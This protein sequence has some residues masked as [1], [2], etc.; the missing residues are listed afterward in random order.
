MREVMMRGLELGIVFVG[1][2]SDGDKGNDLGKL[3]RGLC[4]GL[5]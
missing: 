5:V 4:F 3:T 1:F 2:G